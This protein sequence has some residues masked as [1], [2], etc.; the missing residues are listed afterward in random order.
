VGALAR[1]GQHPELNSARH[2]SPR[3]STKSRIISTI[4]ASGIAANHERPGTPEQETDETF[5]ASAKASPHGRPRRPQNQQQRAI[6]RASVYPMHGLF[7]NPVALSNIETYPMTLGRSGQAW[8]HACSSRSI[9]GTLVTM[10]PSM[11]SAQSQFVRLQPV[12]TQVRTAQ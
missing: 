3:L 10:Q 5:E 4:D 2:I 7:L 1:A 9:S 8:H 11:K 12:G 6:C